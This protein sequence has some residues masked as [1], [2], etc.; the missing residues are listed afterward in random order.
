MHG[1]IHWGAFRSGLGNTLALAFLYMIRCSLHAAALKKNVTQ[2]R[3]KIKVPVI[4]EEELAEEGSGPQ[5]SLRGDG[6]SH[7]RKWSEIMEMD[8]IFVSTNSLIGGA[9]GTP[10][11]DTNVMVTKIESPKPPRMSLKDLLWNYG[12]SQFLSS[13]VGTFGITP[14]IA[15][16]STMYTVRCENM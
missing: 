8:Q 13:L 15:A 10:A 16:T 11:V 12:L 9:G 4:E 7:R 5:Q 6:I 14:S 2:L 3:R 1:K